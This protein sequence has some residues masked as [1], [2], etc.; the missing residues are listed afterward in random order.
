MAAAM[1]EVLAGEYALVSLPA[2]A[3][4]ELPQRADLLILIHDPVETTLVLPAEAWEAIAE[5][6]RGARAQPGYRAVRLSQDFP[7]ET[8]GVLAKLTATLAEAGVAIMAYSTFKTDVIL[9]RKAELDKALG[10]LWDL[11]F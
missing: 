11:R 5:E 8:V 9:V 3:R 7:L 1:L 6:H 10:A 4:P 2:G